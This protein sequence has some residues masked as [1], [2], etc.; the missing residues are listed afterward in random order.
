MPALPFKLNQDRRHHIPRQRHKVTNWPAYE[1]GGSVAKTIAE[2]GRT[3]ITGSDLLYAAVS[4]RAVMKIACPLI[5][6]PPI[7]RICPFRIIVSVI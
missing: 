1:A 5:S 4:K 3:G 7:F 6:R 2:D